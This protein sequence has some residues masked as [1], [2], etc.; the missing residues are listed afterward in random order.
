M[1]PHEVLDADVPLYHQIYLHLK[2]EIADGR[3][4]GRDDFPGEVE[5]ARQF[6]VS[7]ITSRKA[8][9]RL[10]DDGYIERARGKRTRVVRIPDTNPRGGVPAIM[11]TESKAPRSFSY[12]VLARGVE[13][14]PVEAC[15]AF[16]LPAGARLWLCSRL[17]SFNG[18][19][20][21]VTLNAQPIS[22]GKLLPLAKLQKL[23]MTQILRDTGVTFSTLRRRVSASLAPPDVARHLRLTLN[24]ATLVYTFTHHDASDAIVQWVRIWVRSDEPSPDEVFSYATKTWSASS[25]M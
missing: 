21:S 2:A 3:W 4:V 23:P 19:P 17:R 1:T 11:T 10:V 25:S 5:V 14:A 7:V 18:R 13:I 8:L 12:R 16:G 6:G 15:M 9:N 20:H 24:D 22:L